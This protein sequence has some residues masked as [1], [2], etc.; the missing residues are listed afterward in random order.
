MLKYVVITMA[1]IIVALILCFNI[2]AF[3]YLKMQDKSKYKNLMRSI[4]RI[5]LILFIIFVIMFVTIGIK[6]YI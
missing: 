4:S 1:I 6:N 3:I 5:S 2:S